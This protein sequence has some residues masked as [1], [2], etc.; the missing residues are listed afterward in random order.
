MILRVFERFISVNALLVDLF[1]YRGHT[2][3][4]AEVKNEWS[5]TSTFP[6]GLLCMYNDNLH[7]SFTMSTHVRN[8]SIQNGG[9]LRH[10]V[11]MFWNDIISVFVV[12]FLIL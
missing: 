6:I 8:T 7:F 12:S 11:Y 2:P 1:E 3:S 5:C 9:L 10:A 4:F